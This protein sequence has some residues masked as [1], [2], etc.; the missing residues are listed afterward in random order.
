MCQKKD[1]LIHPIGFYEKWIHQAL[2]YRIVV[3]LLKQSI[4]IL[5][6]HYDIHGIMFIFVK[7]AWESWRKKIDRL[8]SNHI[9]STTLS[10]KSW[11]G[12]NYNCSNNF[13]CAS[14]SCY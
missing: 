2:S 13:M 10:W 4:F 14:Y 9:E 5:S 8:L 6:Y 7:K 12:N 1:R 11:K 3:I